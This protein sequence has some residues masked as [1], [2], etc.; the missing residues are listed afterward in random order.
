MSRSRGPELASQLKIVLDRSL[1]IDLKML[2]ADPKGNTE[3]GLP[4]SQELLGR[5]RTPTKTVDILLERIPR[6][7]G[8]LI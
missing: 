2:S 6:G 1:V 7:D 8:V 4:P 5:I 3:D